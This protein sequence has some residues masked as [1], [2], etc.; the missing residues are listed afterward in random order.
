M[1]ETCQKLTKIFW[2]NAPRVSGDH[3]VCRFTIDRFPDEQWLF[4]NDGFR[5]SLRRGVTVVSVTEIFTRQ[6]LSINLV[7]IVLELIILN[8]S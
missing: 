3:G 2:T 8:K 1:I 4:E 6:T 7:L 5:T